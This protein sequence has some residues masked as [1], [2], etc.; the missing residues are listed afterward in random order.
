MNDLEAVFR[1]SAGAGLAGNE[2]FDGEDVGG[3]GGGGAAGELDPLPNAFLAAC[4]A[5]VW[6][7]F[8][9]TVFEVGGGGGVDLA[10]GGRGADTGGG[11]GARGRVGALE[12][13]GFGAAAGGGGGAEGGV[14]VTDGGG[15]GAAEDGFRE[16]IA[17]GGGFAPAGGRGGGRDGNSELGRS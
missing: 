3:G 15:G 9:E 16:L 1:E 5:M 8:S 7:K 12:E 17:E 14:G 4:I 13:G 2:C 6:A 10:V 11:G